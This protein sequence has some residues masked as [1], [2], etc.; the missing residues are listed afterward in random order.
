MSDVSASYEPDMPK[1][2]ITLDLPADGIAH[3]THEEAITLWVSLHAALAA[4][5]LDVFG[6]VEVDRASKG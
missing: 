3:L 4:H 6:P 2:P 5:D 1:F